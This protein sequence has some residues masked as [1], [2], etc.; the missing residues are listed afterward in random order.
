VEDFGIAPLEAMASGRP[1]IAYPVGGAT[2][3]VV[4]NTTGAFFPEQTW[5]SLYT[6]IHHFDPTAWDSTKIREHASTFS[7]DIF[8]SSIHRFVND[9]YEEFEQGLSQPALIGSETI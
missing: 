1:V 7:T 8:K 3:T 5:E 4:A 9:R 6:A 2:E